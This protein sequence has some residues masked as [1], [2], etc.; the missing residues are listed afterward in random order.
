MSSQLDDPE[1]IDASG[2]SAPEP[3]GLLDPEIECGAHRLA[4]A[5]GIIRGVFI[6]IP[7]WTLLAFTL[8]LLV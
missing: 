4:P 8:Y 2:L 5:R 6:A 3:A 7:I 1:L